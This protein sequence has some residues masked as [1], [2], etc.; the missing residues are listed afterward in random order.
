MQKN[1][2]L[3]I[4]IGLLAI[5]ARKAM[6][7][8]VGT[9]IYGPLN[10][11]GGGIPEGFTRLSDGTLIPQVSP[12]PPYGSPGT[13]P[14]PIIGGV[15]SPPVLPALTWLSPWDGVPELEF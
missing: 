12:L 4:G 14:A 10:P 2:V 3:V 6:A 1:L 9:G 7:Q 5:L 13:G 15:I 8:N 11:I